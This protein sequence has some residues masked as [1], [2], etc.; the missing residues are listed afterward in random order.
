MSTETPRPTPEF[1]KPGEASEVFGISIQVIYEW[2]KR[3][4]IKSHLV[5]GRGNK[6]GIRLISTASLREFIEKH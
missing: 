2:I 5:R 3:G 6:S 4:E 1:L